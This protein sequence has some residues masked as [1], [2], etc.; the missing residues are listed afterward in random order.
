ML[1]LNIK[2]L[3]EGGRGHV[4]F[5]KDRVFK[6]VRWDLSAGESTCKLLEDSVSMIRFDGREGSSTRGQKVGQCQPALPALCLG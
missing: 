2:K 5:D 6:T 3:R 1:P 4:K